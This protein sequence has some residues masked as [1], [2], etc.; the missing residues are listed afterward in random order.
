[1]RPCL[2]REKPSNWRP[3]RRYSEPRWF[4]SR[5]VRMSRRGLSPG[6]EIHRPEPKPSNLISRR[7]RQ[8]LR[9]SGQIEEA[10][11]AFE[12]YNARSP[13]F[14]LAD[15]VIAYHENGQPE[16]SKDAAR[17]LLSARRDF[18]IAMWQKRRF[19]VTRPG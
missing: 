13:G 2:T 17:R 12:A 4:Y 9:L 11:A 6:P 7:S 1:M 8:C 15:L 5:A 18:T 14:G 10:I 3:A 16:K 19:V